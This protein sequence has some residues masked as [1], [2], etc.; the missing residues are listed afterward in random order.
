MK[1]ALPLL[2][3]AG[4][5][6]CS[7]NSSTMVKNAATVAAPKKK[8]VAVPVVKY[9]VEGFYVGMFE[10]VKDQEMTEGSTRKITVCIDSLN[11]HQLYGHSIVSGNERPFS[12]S[13]RKE[14]ENYHASVREPGDDPTDGS[15]EFTIYPGKKTIEGV[16]SSNNP[17]QAVTERKYWLKQHAYHYDP[18]LKLP[19]ELANTMIFQ[20]F[21]EKTEMGE[22]LTKDALKKNSSTV[23]LTSADVENMYKG[24]LE[25]L[26]NSIYAR[27]GYAFKNARMR[28][29][30]DSY[31]EWYM[32]VSAD[33]TD[34][35]TEIEKKNITLIKRYEAHANKYYDNFG[36]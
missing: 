13:Y 26:R 15:F 22:T 3:L 20:T 9:G 35:L 32:P 11:D 28:D 21:N 4:L 25:V 17:K 16:W 7:D 24:D 10:A 14:G 23:L 19:E 29:I 30:F 18:S 33:V 36:R 2:L 8:E 5:T 34:Q 27:H 31:V 6:A 12:G 1:I